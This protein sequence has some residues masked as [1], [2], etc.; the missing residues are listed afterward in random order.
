MMRTVRFQVKVNH[1]WNPAYSFY[2]DMILTTAETSV[3]VMCACLMHM[4]P[5]LRASRDIVISSTRSLLSST[6]NGFVR[7]DNVSLAP[8]NQKNDGITVVY[9]YDVETISSTTR[10]PQN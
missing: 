9:K 4:K 5:V 8:K 1:R 7:S 2:N 10:S 3:S 6:R